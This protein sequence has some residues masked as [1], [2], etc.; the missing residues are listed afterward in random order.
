MDENARFERPRRRTTSGR[1]GDSRQQRKSE[2]ISF[3]R[4]GGVGVGRHVYDDSAGIPYPEAELSSSD[5]EGSSV[6]GT[7]GLRNRRWD[8]D[9]RPVSIC[10]IVFDAH[11]AGKWI[12]EWTQ[13]LFGESSSKTDLGGD[14]WLY[15]VRLA[16]RVDVLRKRF[17]ESPRSTGKS[18]GRVAAMLLA[19]A[20]RIWDDFISLVSQCEEYVAQSIPAGHDGS[21][22]SESSILFVESMFGSRLFLAG[23]ER[24]VDD[25]AYWNEVYSHNL[26][27]DGVK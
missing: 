4:K 25:V 13:Q 21:I 10:G 12:F 7:F 24:F 26:D 11:S 19:S 5:G 2:T 22:D 27:D 8:R 6:R 9:E 14:L 1:S 15:V 23:T 16:C 20:S 3:S 17:G 18:G